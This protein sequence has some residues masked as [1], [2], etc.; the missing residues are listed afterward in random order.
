LKIQ[1][2]GYYGRKIFSRSLSKGII[3]GYYTDYIF[4]G[5]ILALRHRYLFA[6]RKIFFQELF[7]FKENFFEESGKKQREPAVVFT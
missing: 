6:R 1:K 5:G 3:P 7:S 4:S 2:G